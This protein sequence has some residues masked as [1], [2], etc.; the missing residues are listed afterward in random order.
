M[1]VLKRTTTY[2]LHPLHPSL[3]FQAVHSLP[4]CGLEYELSQS[5]FIVLFSGGSA[6]RGLVLQLKQ[7]LPWEQAHFLPS[8]TGSGPGHC[9]A[10]FR[11][12]Q[13]SQCLACYFAGRQ[14]MSQEIAFLCL[15][16]FSVKIAF[17]WRHFQ[18]I[19]LPVA[20]NSDMKL[21]TTTDFSQRQLHSQGT[22]ERFAESH[23]MRYDRCCLRVLPLKSNE[24]FSQGRKESYPQSRKKG[25]EEIISLAKYLPCFPQKQLPCYLPQGLKFFQ[26]RFF[27]SL[28]TLHL[29][30]LRELGQFSQPLGFNFL[31]D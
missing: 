15:F 1:A 3:S 19:F 8:C 18:I 11:A 17:I 31:K 27:L 24:A 6:P 25:S 10:V 21:K 20:N 22:L 12:G 30:Q 28:R 5:L 29:I 23:R 16:F 9:N 4:E 13:G 2:N 7:E 26:E 14:W